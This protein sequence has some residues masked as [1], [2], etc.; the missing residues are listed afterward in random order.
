[1]NMD[2]V[3]IHNGKIYRCQESTLPK[4]RWGNSVIEDRRIELSHKL[5]SRSKHLQTE[6][7]LHEALHIESPEW[8][9][10]R[11]KNT[12]RLLARIIRKAKIDE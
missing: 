2:F 3:V 7:L 11:V 8:S 1:M 5:H 4:D 10:N 9:E 6:I 12:A